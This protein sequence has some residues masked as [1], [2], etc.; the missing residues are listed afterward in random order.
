MLARMLA[1]AF[2]L[3]FLPV[4]VDAE[5]IRLENPPIEISAPHLEWLL[6]LEHPGPY[7]DLMDEFFPAFGDKVVVRISPI[8]RAL[9][10]FFNGPAHCF[11][12]GHIDEV[13]LRTTSLTADQLIASD[14]FNTVAIRA[15]TKPGS[16]VVSHLS[17]L[18][19]KRV[20]IDLGIGGDNRVLRHLPHALAVIDADNPLH[21]QTLLM[22]DRASTAIIMDYDYELSLAQNP[23]QSRLVH[24]PAFSLD[25]VEDAVLCKTSNDTRALIDHVN[26]R[27]RAMK[28]TGQLAKILQP[29]P[30]RS[31]RQFA[32]R[33]HPYLN[34]PQ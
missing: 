33:R 3:S 17:D 11:I 5:P 27:I 21:A 16:P 22:Q 9:R 28:T 30:E 25:K 31:A 1:V 12:A 20:V 32:N 8:R 15:Y 34:S 4:K 18:Q 10:Q 7:N 23:D 26:E 13:F 6:S 2:L 14:A 24:D 29:D 19:A